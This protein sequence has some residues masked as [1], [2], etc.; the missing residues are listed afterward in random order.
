MVVIEVSTY[1]LVNFY[2]LDRLIVE[3]VAYKMIALN[4]TNPELS[5]LLECLSMLMYNAILLINV[6]IIN[7]IYT[8]EDI[9][10]HIA[11]RGLILSVLD[12]LKICF[13][14][15]GDILNFFL[16]KNMP[17]IKNKT[18]SFVSIVGY[19]LRLAICAPITLLIFINNTIRQVI[20]S[21]IDGCKHTL[22]LRDNW[23]VVAIWSVDQ[24]LFKAP[25]VMLYKSITVF[26][27][28]VES[29]LFAFSHCLEKIYRRCLH[30]CEAYH[31]SLF[32]AYVT[33]GYRQMHENY[34]T[35]RQILSKWHMPMRVSLEQKK[36]PVYDFI[37]DFFGSEDVKKIIEKITILQT[38]GYRKNGFFKNAMNDEK[39]SYDEFPVFKNESQPRNFVYHTNG[40]KVFLTRNIIEPSR[41]G[42]RWVYEQLI[43]NVFRSLI[44]HL[45]RI[46]LSCFEW[47]FYLLK[48]VVSIVCWLRNIIC[49]IVPDYPKTVYGQPNYFMYR[50]WY[51]V[52]A[53]PL[54][55]IAFPIFVLEVCILSV[56]DPLEKLINEVI[57]SIEVLLFEC[58]SWIDAALYLVFDLI[59][60]CLDNIFMTVLDHLEV[61]VVKKPLQADDISSFSQAL[62]LK[63]DMK[64]SNLN[65]KPESDFVGEYAR[66]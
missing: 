11:N 2:N 53:T 31:Y 42:L 28:R 24:V 23:F 37:R 26:R 57:Q 62:V 22:T 45:T 65:I 21:L 49:C 59:D 36:F 51:F 43:M 63:S 29:F 61:G 52:T 16:E 6:L 25:L 4:L 20:H 15:T 60:Y 39:E 66:Q 46:S 32:I 33:S 64:G 27:V 47:A 14:F 3:G 41:L 38:E 17:S 8:I 50:M 30:V 12:C 58:L 34:L 55:I 48:G 7:I 44:Q 56:L 40:I 13:K 35:P 54:C 5:I 19:Y 1:L 9:V 10:G 18:S